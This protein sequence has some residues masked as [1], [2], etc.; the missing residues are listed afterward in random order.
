[1]ALGASSMTAAVA[2]VLS[3][4]TVVLADV[5]SRPGS[6]YQL[7]TLLLG[8]DLALVA[9]A[10]I[11][12]G[13]LWAAFGSWRRHACALAALVLGAAMV[14]AALIHP[15]DRGAAALL[16]WAGAVGLALALGRAR[17]EGRCLVLGSVAAVVLAHLAVALAQR[18]ADGAIGLGVLGEA[19]ASVIGGRYASSGLTVHP[20]VL[21]AW[22]AVGG[23]GLLALG[24]TAPAPSGSPGSLGSSPSP[25][26]G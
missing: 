23:V 2:I 15:S 11:G 12:A 5:D 14:P 7:H 10:V 3:A 16:R 1:M 22:C 17:G 20:Y 9:L 6:D 4:T 13:G 18:G 26:S 24:G 25:G 21:A 8:S 19:R